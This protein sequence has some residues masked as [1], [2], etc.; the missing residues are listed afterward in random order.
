[1]MPERVLCPI[2]Q[3]DETRPF[4]TSGPKELVRC[5]HCG[6]VYV[7]PRP[8]REEIRHFFEAGY[9]P[10]VGTLQR[11][12]GAW[13]A[14]TLQR[15]AKLIGHLR[16]PGRVL[17]V[18]CAG[19]EFLRRLASE[20]WECHGVEPSLL[21]VEECRRRDLK[22]YQGT[23]LDADIPNLLFDVVTCLDTLYLTLNPCEEV[24]RIAHLLKDDGLLVVELPGYRYRLLRN[25]GFL[26]LLINRRWCHLS[27]TS[28]HLF[29]FSTDSLRRLLAKAGFEIIGIVPE[30]T[31][32]R[33]PALL[34]ML[35]TAYFAV[36]WIVS[37]TTMGR[38]HLA[39]KIV[40]L[41]RKTGTRHGA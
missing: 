4:L 1:M 22:A 41:C 8:H 2:C 9:V 5:V 38:A 31:P 13:R 25:V 27:P 37:A 7:N 40:Y 3:L 11:E 33:G 23:L 16:A 36:S 15:E 10:N 17:D 18:G 28:I 20:G 14:P 21:A 24:E 6:L 34:R 19:G 39:P 29:Y 30:R 12:F 32:R 26:S 35:A